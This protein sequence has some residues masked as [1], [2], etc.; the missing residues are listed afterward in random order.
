MGTNKIYRWGNLIMHFCYTNLWVPDPPPFSDNEGGSRKQWPGRQRSPLPRFPKGRVPCP[1]RSVLL[2]SCR[3]ATNPDHCPAAV[4]PG[5][6]M[7][8]FTPPESRGG[9]PGPKAGAVACE[10]VCLAVHGY[11]GG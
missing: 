9:P 1:T 7:S 5:K 8:V 6:I 10:K 3:A 4:V 11:C 2:Q